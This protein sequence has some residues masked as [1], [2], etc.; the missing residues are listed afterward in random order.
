MRWGGVRS[1]D[2]AVSLDQTTRMES[3]RIAAQP[4]VD[5]EQAA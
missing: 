1:A 2:K 5:L 3:V 4:A